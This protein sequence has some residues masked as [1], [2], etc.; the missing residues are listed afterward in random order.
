MRDLICVHTFLLT[1]AVTLHCQLLNLRAVGNQPGK[2]AI[3]FRREAQVQL[4]H[5][6]HRLGTMTCLEIIDGPL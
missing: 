4:A 1:F 6:G 3:P 2:A 5:T